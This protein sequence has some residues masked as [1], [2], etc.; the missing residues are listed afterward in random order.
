MYSIFPLAFSDPARAYFFKSHG[1]C[2][3]YNNAKERWWWWWGKYIVNRRVIATDSN[4]EGHAYSRCIHKFT[5]EIQLLQLTLCK[6]C[7]KSLEALFPHLQIS[8]RGSKIEIWLFFVQVRPLP[9][10]GFFW[11]VLG[12]NE[13]VHAMQKLHS[14]N[15]IS[16]LF[17]LLGT[18][19]K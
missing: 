17:H 11:V 18:A 7:E 19:C 12:R 8:G 5:V 3:C 9:P 10:S 13:V 2:P 4:G 14:F 16:V 1:Y 15:C 6:N